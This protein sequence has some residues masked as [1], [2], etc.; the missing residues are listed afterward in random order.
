MFFDGRKIGRPI[1]VRVSGPGAKIPHLERNAG[2]GRRCGID[3]EVRG[4]RYFRYWPTSPGCA[5]EYSS[6]GCEGPERP[7]MTTTEVAGAIWKQAAES[8]SAT[9]RAV[10]C[11]LR[12][13]GRSGAWGIE[14]I[15]AH[16]RYEGGQRAQ[17]RAW[18]LSEGDLDG[19]VA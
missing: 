7:M 6:T 16:C 17:R 12:W 19:F 14:G 1:D 15:P 3:I 5:L 8:R 18:A 4:V 9:P 10:Q 2:I 13:G 11:N